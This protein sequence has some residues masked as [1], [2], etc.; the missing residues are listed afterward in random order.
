M[1]FLADFRLKARSQ[2]GVVDPMFV[3]IEVVEIPGH[4][5]MDIQKRI[6]QNPTVVSAW[7]KRPKGT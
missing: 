1:V 2:I 5:V 4:W 6:A 3:K 7:P